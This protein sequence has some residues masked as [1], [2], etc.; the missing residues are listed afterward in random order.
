MF[1]VKE[2]IEVKDI[3]LAC[4]KQQDIRL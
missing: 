2:V 1:E 3:T 4:L